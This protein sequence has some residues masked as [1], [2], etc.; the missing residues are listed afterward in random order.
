MAIN[1]K[2]VNTDLQKLDINSL[3]KA[4]FLVFGFEFYCHQLQRCI[5]IINK[6]TDNYTLWAY[7]IIPALVNVLL[8]LGV[9]MV[10]TV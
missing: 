8:F 5:M 2:P 9:G 4:V 7:R 10:K 3:D 1:T 6:D